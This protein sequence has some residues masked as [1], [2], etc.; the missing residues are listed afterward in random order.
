MD[1]SI[2]ERKESSIAP[3]PPREVLDLLQTAP[4]ISKF[5]TQ[6]VAIHDLI[7]SF[8]PFNTPPLCREFSSE[9]I[10]K[11]CVPPRQPHGVVET[12]YPDP[13]RRQIQSQVTYWEG[14]L[15]GVA[16]FWNKNG[17]LLERTEYREGMKQGKSET[18]GKGP[19]SSVSFFQR[20][21]LHGVSTSID[22]M[23]DRLD[24]L[25]QEGEYIESRFF[26]TKDY[27]TQIQSYPNGVVTTK[28]LNPQGHITSMS[29]QYGSTSIKTYYNSH[30]GIT[31]MVTT[32]SDTHRIQVE[33]FYSS[34]QIRTR[35]TRHT[36][37]NRV[38]VERWRENLSSRTE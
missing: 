19:A 11:K 18:W 28:Y 5:P 9:Y 36:L 15:H 10:K 1:P 24:T 3:L 4:V 29:E 32:N 33:E 13:R 20:G 8:L 25:F 17:K 23:G 38:Q 27:P 6:P 37:T 14:Q 34:G 16:R 2:E 7:F 21:L 12:Y 30:G 22:T 31:E 26:G 35:T